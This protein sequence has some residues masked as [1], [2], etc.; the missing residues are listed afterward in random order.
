MLI[1]VF[2]QSSCMLLVRE[3]ADRIVAV[4][5]SSVAGYI[6]TDT[7][8]AA[9]PGMALL[10]M[11]MSEASSNIGRVSG[12]YHPRESR[13]VSECAGTVLLEVGLRSLLPLCIFIIIIS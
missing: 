11:S 10:T 9:W 6:S 7:G 1:A 8:G 2:V 5:G 12:D 3:D 4:A 13:S